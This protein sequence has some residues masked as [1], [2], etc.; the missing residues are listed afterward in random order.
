MNKTRR[1]KKEMNLLIIKLNKIDGWFD[2]NKGDLKKANKHYYIGGIT[3][4][5]CELLS[6]YRHLSIKKVRIQKLLG[7]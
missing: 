1:Q 3:N 7:Y 4:K 5:D 2:R 6:M